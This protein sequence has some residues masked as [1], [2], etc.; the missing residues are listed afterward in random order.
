MAKWKPQHKKRNDRSRSVGRGRGGA[1]HSCREEAPGD[2]RLGR[3]QWQA[4]HS[5]LGSQQEGAEVQSLDGN[6]QKPPRA[7]KTP[8][9][10]ESGRQT[11]LAQ[12]G[13]RGAHAR[14]ECNG[15]PGSEDRAPADQSVSC[16][17]PQPGFPPGPP[18]TSWPWLLRCPH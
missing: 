5:G 4:G 7:G 12:D 3:G 16:L 8:R 11:D 10:T 17:P 9:P 2:R 15:M 14:T 18:G 13:P 1:P 6:G